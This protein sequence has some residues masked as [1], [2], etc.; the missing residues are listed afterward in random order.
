MS[1]W[2]CTMFARCLRLTAERPPGVTRLAVT[3]LETRDKLLHV[4]IRRHHARFSD[5][6]WMRRRQTFLLIDRC[7]RRHA[8]SP[9]PR[10][11]TKQ[12]GSDLAMCIRDPD[13]VLTATCRSEPVRTNSNVGSPYG[14]DDVQQ[15]P[16]DLLADSAT[17]RTV[18]Q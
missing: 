7:E 6:S 14:V 15:I 11:I 10:A 2:L 8:S 4:R 16:G 1:T 12:V 9:L 5:G 13:T 3:D 18:A 17:S